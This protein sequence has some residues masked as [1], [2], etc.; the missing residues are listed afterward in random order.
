MSPATLTSHEKLT[1]TR[2][3][4]GLQAVPAVTSTLRAAGGCHASLVTR[5]VVDTVN[6]VCQRML[7]ILNIAHLE[8]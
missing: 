2:L 8:D 6:F 3:A 5:V 7:I 1:V 4:I